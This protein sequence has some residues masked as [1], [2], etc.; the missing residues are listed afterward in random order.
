MLGIS[1]VGDMVHNCSW[2]IIWAVKYGIVLP[3]YMPIDAT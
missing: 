3:I 2:E 1:L